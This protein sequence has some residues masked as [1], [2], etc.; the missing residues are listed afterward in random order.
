MWWLTILLLLVSIGLMAA[1]LLQNRSA[2]LGG[3]FGG[4]SEGFHIRRGGEKRLFQVTVGLSALF[5]VIAF[6]HLFVS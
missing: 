3:A 4:G 5:L 2:G 6:A 1:I